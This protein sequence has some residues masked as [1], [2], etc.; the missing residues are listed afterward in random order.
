MTDQ[1]GSQA[2]ARAL[3]DIDRAFKTAAAA[4]DGDRDLTRTFRLA[5]ELTEVLRER[6]NDAANL[7]VLAV[8]RTFEAERLSLAGL[9][10]RFGVSK[11]RAAQMINSAKRA[12]QGKA[13]EE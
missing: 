12:D 8:A 10:E 5:T 2:V 13:E 7:R 3:A 9:A 6:T 1:D 4:I 11:A